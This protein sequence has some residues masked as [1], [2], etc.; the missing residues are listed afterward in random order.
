MTAGTAAPILE[1]RGLGKGFGGVQAVS[2]VSFT[3]SDERI[4][5]IIGPNG[6]GKSTLFN[7]VSRVL[8]ATT[9]AIRLA[10]TDISSMRPDHVFRH[11]LS[12]T[13]QNTRLFPRL[14]LAENMQLAAR[15]R[16]ATSDVAAKLELV[17][18]DDRRDV[19]AGSL[20]YGDQKLL[21]LSMSLLGDPAIVLLD[22]PLAGVHSDIVERIRRVV[23]DASSHTTFVL[24]EHNVGFLM[25]ICERILVMNQGSLIADG[26][27]ADVRSD[28]AVINAYLGTDF[29]AAPTLGEP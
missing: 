26:M 29:G 8:P 14:T 3:I 4:V 7:L 19:P 6:S 24:V 28:Q 16:R 20:S 1:V 15:G 10:G 25:R 17:E 21:E 18:L 11:G 23:Q 5:G 9:G 22:E 13:F 27:P 2:D 12:R